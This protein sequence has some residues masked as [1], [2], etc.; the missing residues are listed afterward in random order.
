MSAITRLLW[1]QPLPSNGA[2]DIQ[3]LWAS[4]GRTREPILTK[5]VYNSK[6]GPQ[7]RDQILKFLKFKMADGRHVGKY[8]KCH[9]SPTNGPTG[10][11]LGCGRIPSCS[12]HWKCYRPNSYYHGTDWDE[13]WVVASKQHLCC[14]TVS[15][16]LVVTAN[17]I[18]NILVLWGVEIKNINNFDETW[19]TAVVQKMKF[20]GKQQILIQKTLEVLSLLRPIVRWHI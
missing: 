2:L 8:S 9:N 6:L 17:R 12:R 11:Q 19:M 18:V 14:K 16:V 7:S 1:Q 5:F 15:L 20:G 13:S 3:Q 4:G 10:T